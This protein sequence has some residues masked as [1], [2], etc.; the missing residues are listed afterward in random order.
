MDYRTLN[1]DEVLYLIRDSDINYNE[2]IFKKYSCYLKKIAREYAINYNIDFDDAYQEALLALNYAINN[3]SNDKN[4]KFITFINLCVN[5]RL[6]DYVQKEVFNNIKIVNT[7]DY[8]EYT[9]GIDNT[10]H[11]VENYC[12]NEQLISFKNSLDIIESSIFELRING[13]K[14]REIAKLLDISVYT[15]NNTL[16]K[17]RKKMSTYY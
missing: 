2:L 10:Y 17:I 13:F 15:V 9:T 14:Y 6:K 4:A 5:A 3:Y 1:D 8:Y 7:S 11:D 16:K 12:I